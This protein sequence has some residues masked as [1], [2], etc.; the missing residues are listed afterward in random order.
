MKKILLTAATALFTLAL[1]ASEPVKINEKVIEAF[2]KSFKH[3]KN[4]SWHE[5]QNFYE[6]KFLH[7]AVDSRITYDTEGN[8]LRTIRYY[9]E[10]QLPLFVK[11]KLQNRFKDKKVFGVT[12]L[13]VEGGLDYY[14]VLED[15]TKW[16]HV[17]CD[18]VGN[19]SVYKKYNKA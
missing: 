17:K 19:M 14:I 10:D 7:N 18:A 11:A 4:V 3:A 15:A 16:T 13:A 6:V 9:G 2:Q 12:E 5:Y 1:F 8:I